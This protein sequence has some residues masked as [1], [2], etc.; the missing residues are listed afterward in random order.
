M[1]PEMRYLCDLHKYLREMSKRD[2]LEPD[3]RLAAL[4]LDM[5]DYDLDVE[6]ETH[7]FTIDQI[8]ATALDLCD[9]CKQIVAGLLLELLASAGRTVP[10]GHLPAAR[11][12]QARQA[13]GSEDDGDFVC[14][15]DIPGGCG[16]AFVKRGN[17]LVHAWDVHGA[18]FYKLLAHWLCPPGTPGVVCRWPGCPLTFSTTATCGYHEKNCRLRPVS[19][20]A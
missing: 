7:V 16:Q 20:G 10:D 5:Q 6:G 1:A 17:L 3:S 2:E 4:W 14:P 8:P 15:M 13:R 11:A 19:T 12:Q 9:H 18:N